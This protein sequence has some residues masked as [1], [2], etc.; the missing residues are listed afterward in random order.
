MLEGTDNGP[1]LEDLS[2]AFYAELVSNDVL[3]ETATVDDR[4]R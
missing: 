3:R 1:T 4:S 2:T